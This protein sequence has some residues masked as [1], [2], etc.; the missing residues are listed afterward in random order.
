MIVVTGAAGFIGSCLIGFLNQKDITDIIAV[1]RFR[2]PDKKANLAG[3]DF[4]EQIE[5]EIFLG[6]LERHH[7]K[8]QFI[9]HLGARTDTAE[10][11]PEIFR[12]L[13]TDY[14]QKL[15][16]QCSQYGI[17]VLYASSAATY[18]NG[19][20]GFSDNHDLISRLKPMNLYARSK[21][22]FDVWTLQQK[23]MPPFWAGL[24]FFNVYGPNEYHKGR[25][26]SVV[27]HA[28]RQVKE[29]GRL[30]LFRSHHPDFRDG[31]QLRDFIY[32]KDV[33]EICYFFFTQK[34]NSGIYN[35]GTGNARTFND[36]ARAAFHALD[37][38]VNIDYVE[39]PADIKDSYQYFTQAEI[40]KLRQAGYIEPFIPLEEGVKDY[41]KNYLAEGKY[42]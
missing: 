27:F 26:A 7:A 35:V 36:L 2:N 12:R 39:T 14:S 41:Y 33:L 20:Q 1:D 32:V 24:K 30:T 6:W 4:T 25:M 28:F 40:G 37:R 42:F 31:E 8:V 3:K 11:N 21:H 16:Q 15:W 38:E 19:E 10:T 22:D 34:P 29:T 9:F 13:N 17:P 5:R 23:K 18:G